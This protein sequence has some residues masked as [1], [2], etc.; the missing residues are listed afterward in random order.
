M[1]ITATSYAD[2]MGIGITACRRSVPHVQ[3]ML[4]GLDTSLDELTRAVG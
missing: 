2:D 4:A 3:R 1:N